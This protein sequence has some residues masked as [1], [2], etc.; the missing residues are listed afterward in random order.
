M[1]SSRSPERRTVIAR[2][3]VSLYGTSPYGEVA[4]SL[5]AV[6]NFTATPRQYNKIYLTWGHPG[7]TWST[8]RLVRNYKGY[9]VDERN[10]ETIF[11]VDNASDS[12]FFLAPEVIADRWAYYSLFVYVDTDATWVKSA[13]TRIYIPVDYG[14]GQRMF[15]LVPDVHKTGLDYNLDLYPPGVQGQA[16]AINPLAAFM[17][18]FGYGYD[19]IRNDI[20][21]LLDLSN[22]ETMLYDLVPVLM[23]Q[24]GVPSETVLAPEQYRRFLRNAV[25]LFKMKGTADCARGV[26][27]SVTG[28]AANISIGTNLL[29]DSNY[30]DFIGG[31]G[32][33]GGREGP[34]PNATIRCDVE[35]LPPTDTDTAAMLITAVGPGVNFLIEV[36]LIHALEEVTNEVVVP[37]IPSRDYTVSMVIRANNIELAPAHLV[38]GWYDTGMNLLVSST[39][40]DVVTQQNVDQRVEMTA[41]APANAAFLVPAIVIDSVKVGQTW[42]VRQVMISQSSDLRP[43]QP[44]H[45]VR[46]SLIADRINLV[47]NPSFTNDL[48]GWAASN[49]V[50]ISRDTS[51]SAVGNASLLATYTGAGG[52][53]SPPYPNVRIAI[54]TRLDTRYVLQF[55]MRADSPINVRAQV[56]QPVRQV[57]AATVLGDY[58]DQAIAVDSGEFVFVA[59][60]FIAVTYQTL[61]AVYLPDPTPGDSFWLDAVLLEPQTA[62]DDA[63]VASLDINA[64]RPY[65]D[66]GSFSL[67]GEYFWGGEPGDSKSHFYYRRIFSQ[68]RLAEILPRYLPLGATYTLLYAR[69]DASSIVSGGYIS[70]S[71]VVIEP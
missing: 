70:R 55:R 38:I 34:G 36:G 11:A 21:S 45:D 41:T 61:F 26:V 64:V 2:Y 67:T 33:W 15:D 51:V 5:Y 43:Y 69:E 50:D 68:Q 63:T 27:S 17:S 56:Q 66:G 20:N 42:E 22:S 25:H 28:W 3:G 29:W 44:G 40:A 19:I 8:L 54:D 31:I 13:D 62:Y 39:S 14:G 30:S 32:L 24:F 16:M 57:G 60:P 46:I 9:P 49:D 53:T 6:D 65:F 10:G 71:D 59:I 37:V 18:V 35:W 48:S 12:Q 47:P 58:A 23:E 4:E 1:S 7:G 52:V